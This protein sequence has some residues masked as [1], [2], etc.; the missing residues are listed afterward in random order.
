MAYS[1]NS[2]L[3]PDQEGILAAILHVLTALLS[4]TADRE[5]TTGR[6]TCNV[7]AINGVTPLM[8]AGVAGTG[9]HRVTPASDTVAGMTSV[10]MMQ[11]AQNNA[12]LALLYNKIS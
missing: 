9:S 3:P 2:S 6:T 11:Q 10:Y 7:S 4:K 1:P 12:A 5:P 8:G